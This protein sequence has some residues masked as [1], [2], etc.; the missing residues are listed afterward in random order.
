MVWE[1][2]QTLSLVLPGA[3]EAQAPAQGRG[4]R[5]LELAGFRAW[6]LGFRVCSLGR[7]GLRVLG[8]RIPCSSEG[9]ILAIVP[10]EFQ[11]GSSQLHGCWM[12]LVLECLG[13]SDERPFSSRLSKS[14]Q[15][16]CQ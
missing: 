12:L 3:A 16:Q 7:L 9:L 15:E 8:F 14:R 2:F 4:L 11:H 1:S 13:E 5:V 10:T 6:I